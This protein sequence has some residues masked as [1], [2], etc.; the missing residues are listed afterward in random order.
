MMGSSKFIL[1]ETGY[2]SG[3]VWIIGERGRSQVAFDDETA[4]QLVLELGG[5]LG[6]SVYRA[7]REAPVD[8]LEPASEPR[9]TSFAGRRLA[10][11]TRMRWPL[12]GRVS[13]HRAPR[14]R[15]PT[16]RRASIQRPT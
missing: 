8:R 14:A 10:C 9:V 7:A 1:T 16:G 4:E 5:K 2:G 12:T 11:G 13:P 15:R 3:H 6:L